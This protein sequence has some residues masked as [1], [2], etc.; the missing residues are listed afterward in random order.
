MPIERIH[1]QPT[2]HI[3]PIDDT[4]YIAIDAEHDIAPEILEE[5]QKLGSNLASYVLSQGLIVSLIQIAPLA[6]LHPTKKY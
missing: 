4:A 5:I 3:K 6:N 2:R 1:I